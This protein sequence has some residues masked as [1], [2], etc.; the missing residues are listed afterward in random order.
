MY[1]QNVAKPI[2]SLDITSYLYTNLTLQSPVHDSQAEV[3]IKPQL[4]SKAEW[5]SKRIKNLSTIY[6]SQRLNSH[7]QLGRLYG[8]IWLKL[9]VRHR[10]LNGH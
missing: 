9:Q 6:T 3:R 10:G 2:Q 5:L 4:S 8:I 7:Y 1:I